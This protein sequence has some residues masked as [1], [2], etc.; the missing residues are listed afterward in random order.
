MIMDLKHLKKKLMKNNRD[1]IA[2]KGTK[3]DA[4]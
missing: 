4:K 1:K 2:S 3:K